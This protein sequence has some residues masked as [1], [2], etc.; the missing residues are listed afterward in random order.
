[1]GRIGIFLLLGCANISLG[2]PAPKVTKQDLIDAELAKLQGT[3]KPV[4]FQRDGVQ[5]PVTEVKSITIKGRGVWCDGVEIAKITEFDP[6]AS[7]KTIEYQFGS[8]DDDSKTQR[9]IYKLEGDSFIECLSRGK[10]ARPK[11]FVSTKGSGHFLLKFKRV[12]AK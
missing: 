1:M 5:A 2:V 6:T 4:E 3:W 8:G 9:A 11:E 10:D 7:P 12:E